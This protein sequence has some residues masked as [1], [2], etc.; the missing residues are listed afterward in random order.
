VKTLVGIDVGTSGT[1]ALVMHDDGV[2]TRRATAEY[3]L[4]TPHPGWAEQDPTDWWA[5]VETVLGQVGGTRD[6]DAIGLTGQM[7]GAVFLDANGD[8]VRPAML[9]NDQRTERECAQIDEIV[10]ASRVRAITWNPPLTGFQL[11]KL[12]WLRT[13][14]PA[15]FARVRS[16]LLPK[17]YIRFKLT[18]E[19]ITDVA[20]ASGTGLL[21]IAKRT[22]STEMLEALDLDP[23][24]FPR[25]VESG[26]VAGVTRDGVPIAAG[27]GDQAAAGVGTG[28]VRPG[29]VSVCLGT[30]GVVF[31]ALDALPAGPTE[32]AQTF[33]HANGR[34][35][36]M[37]VM[38]SCGG[39]VRWLRDTMY[40]GVSYDD[41]TADAD[42]VS[43]GADGVTF[44]PYLTG[45]RSPHNDPRATG[46]FCGLTVRHT[47]AHLAR[48]VF[49]GVTYGLLDGLDVLR[50]TGVAP[51][52]LRLTGGGAVS[53]FWRQLIAD[54][55]G[56]P[57]V[58]LSC[59]EGPGYGA[60][61]L[62]GVAANIWPTI[63]DACDAV[64]HIHH[65]TEPRG[66]DSAS[67]YATAA[68]AY[69]E[70]YPHLRAWGRA[71]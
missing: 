46:A 59:D 65:T 36:V 13:H 8:V 50:G 57:C 29:I 12:L 52:Q 40:P 35:H 54:V 27:A 62:A 6:V 38:L 39:A 21:D 17:D 61:L 60:A 55:T 1:K 25:V 66:G 32:Q 30:S 31:T 45:E 48:A 47:R 20:D 51:T 4:S 33:C 7:H 64:I 67:R 3:P 18:G 43:P 34:W 19:R 68:R 49:E 58:T 15:A 2:V 28:T 5:A 70:L 26:E 41:I 9:W 11:P 69:R 56:T 42:S 10:G 71:S 63:A 44:L 22:W 23:S 14:E 24:L 53:P 16:V 37:A